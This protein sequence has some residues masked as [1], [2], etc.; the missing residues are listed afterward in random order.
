ME[1]EQTYKCAKLSVDC[2][3]ND[4][5]DIKAGGPEWLGFDFFVKDTQAE[6]YIQYIKATL[7]SL[8]IPLNSIYISDYF[9][10]TE[11]ELWNKERI[12]NVIKKDAQMLK[13][14]ASRSYAQN[15]QA[16]QL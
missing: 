10:L 12:Y 5:V 6:E 8:D 16:K 13:F 3:P 1:N 4:P 15:K 11:K 14:E 7:I 2:T 9:L